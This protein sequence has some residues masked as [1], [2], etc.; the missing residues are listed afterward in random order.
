M[1]GEPERP[2]ALPVHLAPMSNADDVDGARTIVNQIH[3]AVIT[4]TNAIAIRPFELR[5]SK[6]P[7]LLL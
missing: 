5:G 6:R 2:A 3:D 4:H 1:P 7:R